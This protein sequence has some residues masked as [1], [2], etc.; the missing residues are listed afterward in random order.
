MDADIDVG[1]RLRAVRTQS[2]ISQRQLAKRADVANATIS[3]IE[4]GKLNPTVGALKK[5]L[6]G[7]PMSLGEFFSEGPNSE[8]DDI[9]F[10]ARDLIELSDGGVSYRQVGHDLSD[11]AIQLLHERYAPGA[12]TGRHQ[13]THEGEECGIV[14][15][16]EL[17]VT[18][19]EQSKILRAG[20][21]YY[22]D[23]SKPHSFKNEGSIEC[24]V[25]S[26]CTPPSF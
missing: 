5:I 11:K 2:G 23:S 3:Q 10:R 22:F 8:R 6:G 16:G 9:F 4:A 24:E 13:F 14:L 17:T 26:A 25:I 12:G 7:F 15:K 1:V 19:E 18:V 20:D 21:A